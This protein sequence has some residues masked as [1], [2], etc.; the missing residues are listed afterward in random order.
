MEEFMASNNMMFGEGV[1]SV[2]ATVV[3]CLPAILVY[4]YGVV[5]GL[6]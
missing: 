3:M 2:S 4:E 5:G 1:G 6:F